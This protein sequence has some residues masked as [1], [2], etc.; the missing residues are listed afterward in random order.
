[1]AERLTADDFFTGLFAALALR[2]RSALTLRSTRFDEAV[3]AIYDNLREH[4]KEVGVDVRFRI[5]LHPLYGDSTTIRDSIT[6]AAQRDI[7][8][9]DNPEF[10]DIRLKLNKESAE[11]FLAKLPVNPQLYIDMA[12]RFLNSYQE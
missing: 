11:L 3:A 1:M 7:I 8:S 10:Q 9:L 2:G 5:L 12:D 6:R 4:A